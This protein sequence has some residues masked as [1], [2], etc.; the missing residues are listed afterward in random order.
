MADARKSA[1]IYVRRWRAEKTDEDGLPVEDAPGRS[2]KRPRRTFDAQWRE[3]K[4]LTIFVHDE[5]GRME[6][7][8]QTLM[9]GTFLGPDAMAELVAMH[10]HRLGAARRQH[11]LRRR[12][13]AV[14]LG[15]DPDHRAAGE[16]GGSADP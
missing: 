16:I 1:A 4:L 5:Q 10:L 12:R 9:D 7:E 13:G 3:P 8:S 14:D 6:K 15:P 2:K 11:H